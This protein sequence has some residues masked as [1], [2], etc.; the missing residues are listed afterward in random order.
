MPLHSALGP[1][2]DDCMDMDIQ[3]SLLVRLMAVTAVPVGD[4]A[5]ETVGM[6][7]GP[8]VGEM[9]RITLETAAVTGNWFE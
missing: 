5:E 8:T 3:P 7:V 2:V 1:I 6:T 4:G 9:L